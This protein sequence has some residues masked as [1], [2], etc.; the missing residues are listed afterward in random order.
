MPLDILNKPGRLSE[1]EMAI[2]RTHASVGFELLAKQGG[3]DGEILSVVRHHHEYLDG[4][5]YP[6]GLKANAI[7]DLVR[8]TTICDIYAALIER[9][10]YK[11]PMP[12]EQAF[13]IMWD[14]GG[15]L[16]ADLLRAFQKLIIPGS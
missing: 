4:T 10:A 6:D 9:R 3:F 13:K 12:A 15:K 1:E 5:G 7:I 11:S 2:M 14:M 8:L 16:D